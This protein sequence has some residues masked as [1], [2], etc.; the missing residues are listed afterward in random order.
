M[1]LGKASTHTIV[2]GGVE[3]KVME[4]EG[5]GMLVEV[6][7]VSAGTCRDEMVALCSMQV[8]IWEEDG[9]GSRRRHLKPL[10]G[11]VAWS[12]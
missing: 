1:A 6:G 12:Q 7:E 2:V 5:P 4:A 11:D 9:E 3:A 10:E 8:G